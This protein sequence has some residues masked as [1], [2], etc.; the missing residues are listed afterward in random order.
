MTDQLIFHSWHVL[1]YDVDTPNNQDP[2]LRFPMSKGRESMVYLSF[3][4]DHYDKLPWAIV[5]VHGH[6]EAWHQEDEILSLTRSLNRIA[7]ARHGYISLRCDW[8]PSCPAEMRPVHG[9]SAIWGPDVFKKGTEAAIAGNW[10]FL[11]PNDPL[12]ETIASPCC[13]QFAV[14]RQAVMK[15]PKA[16]YLRLR[17]WLMSSLLEDYLSGRVIEKIWAFLFTGQAV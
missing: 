14:T 17:D 6:R 8:Y 10:R 9:D 1:E 3:I 13:A 15:R 11:F 2:M 12:P 5:F 16:D 4:I 7:L